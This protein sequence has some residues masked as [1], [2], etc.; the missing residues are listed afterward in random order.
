MSPDELNAYNDVVLSMNETNKIA[1]KEAKQITD[2]VL[3]KEKETEIL[4]T[5]FQPGYIPKTA[6]RIAFD[7]LVRHHQ[8]DEIDDEFVKQCEAIILDAN[9]AEN[10][11]HV[12]AKIYCGQWLK[13]EPVI[14]QSP[15]WAYY[16]NHLLLKTKG[17]IRV[18]GEETIATDP[19]Y[20]VLLGRMVLGGR[21]RRGEPAI[22]QCAKSSLAYAIHV[23]GGRYS[24]GES[25]IS[26]DEN[27]EIAYDEFL[28]GKGI[29]R[30]ITNANS[31]A[32][33][34]DPNLEAGE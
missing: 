14:S 31:L 8:D 3:R 24:A 27:I 34:C 9:D 12:A 22:N 16:Y 30:Q 11:Y 2:V 18:I 7:A 20:S 33:E 28:A 5:G 21:F 23:I 4:A 6:G 10:A 17:Q 25:A 32:T 19:A 13:A 29:I 15:E 1:W 26:K